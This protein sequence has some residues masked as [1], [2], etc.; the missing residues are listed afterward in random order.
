MK[1]NLSTLALSCALFAAILAPSQC[2]AQTLDAE[3]SSFLTLIN[4]FRAQN[5]AGPLQVSIVL[6]NAAQWMSG[7]MAAK[8]YFSHSDSLG[9]DAFSRMARRPATARTC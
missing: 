3:Q 1:R 2:G 5:G 7:D 9:R 6:Q 8:S 4:N